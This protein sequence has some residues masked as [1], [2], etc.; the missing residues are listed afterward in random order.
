V[1]IFYEIAFVV[2]LIA[3]VVFLARPLVEAYSDRIRLHSKALMEDS[4][5]TAQLEAKVNRLESEVMDLKMQLKT[6]QESTEFALKL[7][8]PET[9]TKVIVTDE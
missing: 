5:P 7:T 3:V 8:Q 2:L 1:I 9:Q 6:V 4:T